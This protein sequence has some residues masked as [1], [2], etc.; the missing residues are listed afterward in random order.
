MERTVPLLPCRSVDESVEF[1]RLL[2]FECTYRQQRP[3]ATAVVERGNIGIHLFE[4]AGFD[5]AS[6]YASVLIVT[7]DTDVL[8]E[9]FAAGLRT[10]LGRLPFTG[11]PRITRPRKKQGTSGGFSVID[12][13][14]NWLRVVRAGEPE[15][16]ET[17]KGMARVLENAARQ[18]DS[19]GDERA[20]I[21]ILDAGLARYSDAGPV[22]R[23]P[24]L[25]YLAELQLRIGEA[26]AARA[27]LA[28][29]RE[30]PL[31][32]DDRATLQPELDAARELETDD[33]L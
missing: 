27:T 5:P 22:E 1:Y 20:A 12:P 21:A 32:A 24:A 11:I 30:T 28:E 16:H 15:Q 19:R 10:G 31:S 6:S 2:G 26:E 29:V 33:A 7:P 4:M 17:P 23:V 18:G 25:V 3:Y 13:G 14:G 9:A 8:F